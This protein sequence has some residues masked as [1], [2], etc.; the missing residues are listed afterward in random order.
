M[1][2]GLRAGLAKLIAPTSKP[3]A[4]RSAYSGALTSRLDADWILAGTRSADQETRYDLKILRN[5]ARDLSRNTPLMA[6]YHQLAAENIVGP[7]GFRLQAK[8]LT[9]D[10]KLFDQAN[11]KIEA[12]WEAWSTPENCDASGRYSLRELMSLA[13]SAWK[14]DGEILIRLIKGSQ[15]NGWNLSLQL[16]DPDFLD[17]TWNR[18]RTNTSN[19]I[20]QGVE[21]D[22]LG[23]PVA[24]WL[25]TRHPS[26]T[27]LDR[28]RIRVPAEEIIHFFIPNRP[29]Q[30]RG[31]PDAACVLRQIKMLDG[32]HEAELVAARVASATMA[33][34]ETPNPENAPIDPLDS[35]A[36]EQPMEVEPG[37]FLRLDPGQKLA[38]WDPQHPTSAFSEFTRVELH[39]IAA[40]LGVSYGSLT[41]DLS[42]ANYSSMRVGLIGERDRWR[43]LQESFSTHVLR[44]I[45]REWLPLAMLANK[46]PGLGFDPARWQTV[47]FQPR[48]FQSVDPIKEIT[49]KLLAV[50]AGTETLTRMAAEEGR[51][52]E[53]VIIERKQELDLFKEYGVP[54]TIATA[55]TE[56]DPGATD[57]PNPADAAGGGAGGRHLRIAGR[58]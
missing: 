13:A 52:L 43:R 18:E 19:A 21:I 37:N 35:G 9:Q 7:H 45:Y 54:T 47:K 56:K 39:M 48:G 38:L 44:R 11:Q 3:T 25:W 8:N 5:R 16:L 17:E 1:L 24:Y 36:N 31:I 4:K 2:E 12:A 58:S 32:Y 42:Q 14:T 51:D 55:I 20:R 15:R 6:R 46:L 26:D 23:A 57:E 34:I 40:G 33:A 53:E 22:D 50:N 29:Q 10:G 49:G 28:N 30:N 41:G 27:A